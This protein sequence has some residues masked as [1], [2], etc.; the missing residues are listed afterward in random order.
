MSVTLR[1]KELK[2]GDS[3]YYLD[4]YENG[5]RKYIFLKLKK[6]AKPKDHVERGKNKQDK[7]LAEK[8]C[9]EYEIKLKQGRFGFIS[10]SARKIDFVD[11]F[12]SKTKER[13][14]NGIDH[15]A[16][17][18]TLKHLKLFVDGKSI[19]IASRR[20]MVGRI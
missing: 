9:A 11:Y 4:V 3:S 15:S 14:T 12:E 19:P 10:S 18:S 20:R 17:F 13:E 8:E 16:W 2:N 6:I 1:T 7:L 5:K